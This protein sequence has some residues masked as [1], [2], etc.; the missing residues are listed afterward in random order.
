MYLPYSPYSIKV[1]FCNIGCPDLHP[2]GFD[3]Q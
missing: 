2:K 1:F 3:D